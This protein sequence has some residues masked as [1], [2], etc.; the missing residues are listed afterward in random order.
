MAFIALYFH[1]T[2]LFFDNYAIVVFSPS[3]VT[4]TSPDASTYGFFIS[5]SG[6]HPLGSLSPFVVVL[7]TFSA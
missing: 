5:G 1:S 7:V 3:S 6:V 4:S 2:L